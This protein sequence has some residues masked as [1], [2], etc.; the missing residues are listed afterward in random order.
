MR[1]YELLTIHRPE[2]AEDEVRKETAGVE[3]FLSGAGATVTGTDFW[4]KRRFAY[5]ID[6]VKEGYYTVMTFQGEPSH[7]ADLDRE[8]SLA[9]NVMRHKL[10]R[11][12]IKP[13]RSGRRPKDNGSSDEDQDES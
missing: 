8:L 3:A 13:A 7:V 11:P 10:V 1:T 12:D 2:L 6:K 4:G 5:E 9:D